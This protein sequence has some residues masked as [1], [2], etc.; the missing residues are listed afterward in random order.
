MKRQKARKYKGKT[1]ADG[2]RKKDEKNL[3][4]SVDKGERKCYY[5]QAVTNEPEKRK[6]VRST[7]IA[8]DS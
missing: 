7:R 1:G 5:T 4:K 2:S 3:K 6:I 8:C